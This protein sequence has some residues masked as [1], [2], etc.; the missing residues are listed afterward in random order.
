MGVY[1]KDERVFDRA[2]GLEANIVETANDCY[3]L[4]DSVPLDPTKDG[5]FSDRWRNEYEICRLD[6]PER[7]Q[8][9]MY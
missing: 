3:L 1:T 5:A 8:P 4:D 9:F 7:T 2:S 6:A